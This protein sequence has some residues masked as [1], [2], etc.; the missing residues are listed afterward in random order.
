MVCLVS[1]NVIL[2]KRVLEK[3][4]IFWLISIVWVWFDVMVMFFCWGFSNFVIRVVK[5]D[6]FVFDFLMSIMVCL[7]GM[8]RFIVCSILG[9]F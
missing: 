2:L 8:F 9:L 6:L 4:W 5:V 7:V 1:F 3:V